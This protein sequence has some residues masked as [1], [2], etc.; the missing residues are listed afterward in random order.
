F[1]AFDYGVDD[2]IVVT[3]AGV[4][5]E[6]DRNYARPVALLTKLV[7]AARGFS[8]ERGGEE[9]IKLVSDQV[10]VG[11]PENFG[12]SAIYGAH[13]S[14]EGEGKGDVIE[15]IDQFLEIALRAHD[16]LAQLIKLFFGW[17]DSGPILQALQDVL[18]FGHLALAAESVGGKQN[19][20]QKE[21]GRDRPQAIGKIFQLFPGQCGDRG[22]Q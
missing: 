5:L 11:D 20:E 15:R 8:L 17:C 6:R 12:G 9:F 1:I 21:S 14:I 3:A 2:A 10:G 4:V 22:G 18:E 7:E 19:S 13:G 16:Q